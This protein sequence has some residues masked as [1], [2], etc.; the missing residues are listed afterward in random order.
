[1]RTVKKVI[2][3]AVMENKSWKQEMQI[4]LRNY[5]ATSHAST[6]VP[7]AT[8]LFGRP[9]KIRLPQVMTQ[10]K[11]D[12]ILRRND[13]DAK[14]RMKSYA[15]RK[16]NVKRN[17][18]EGELVLLRNN[19]KNKQLPSYDPRPYQVVGRK[20]SM[21][22]AARDFRTVTRNSSFFKPITMRE[23][24]KKPT[25][26][27]LQEGKGPQEIHSELTRPKLPLTKETVTETAPE[28][29]TSLYPT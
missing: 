6:K 2:K 10:P 27:V 21:I 13:A 24:E 20:G 25:K 5:R 4:F 22:T 1:M 9:I 29:G 19:E 12:T 7:P 16:P 14:L 15:E 17:T 8:V 11:D 18:I 28:Q 26:M 23:D 3:T